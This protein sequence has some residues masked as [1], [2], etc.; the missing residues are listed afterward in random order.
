MLGLWVYP[1]NNHLTCFWIKWGQQLN[2]LIMPL[3]QGIYTIIH[4]AAD[5]DTVNYKYYQ[6]YAGADTTAVINGVSVTM[7][8]ASTLD[9]S[10]SSISGTNVWVL[11]EPIN[12]RNGSPTL[13]NY[14]AP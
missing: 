10:I 8:A 5:A 1:L 2:N 13:S 6:V 11:G 4:A 3:H 7:A 12:T 14:P 9:I